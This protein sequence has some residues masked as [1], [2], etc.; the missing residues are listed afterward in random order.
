MADALVE[1]LNSYG[2]QPVFLP[3]TG[4]EPPDVYTYRKGALGSPGKLILVG[5]LS[6][7][8][9]A[10]SQLQIETGQYADIEGKHTSSKHASASVSFLK[11]ALACIGITAVPKLSLD[12]TGSNTLVFSFTGVTF[13]GVQ[14]AALHDI[15][16]D[17][18]F[19]AIPETDI[20]SG[21]L[22]IAYQYLYA[23]KLHLQRADSHSFSTNVS[24][25]VAEFIDLG[26][27]GKVEVANE[28]TMSFEPTEK[29]SAAFAYMAGQIVRNN[30][31]GK[32]EFKTGMVKLGPAEA[33][34]QVEAFIPH[35]GHVL[36]ASVAEPSPA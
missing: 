13:K 33:T 24:G 26:Q 21:N 10:V 3:M 6:K 16:P 34:E 22:H 25:K 29:V 8:S 9:A 5:D 35:R 23:R 4:L 18:T 17:L 11:E 20:T 7:Y 12:F 27:S 32:L 30:A 31:T 2:F 19:G 36:A 15:L 14:P 28:T 1:M